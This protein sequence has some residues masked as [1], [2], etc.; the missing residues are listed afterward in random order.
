M[1]EKLPFENT[2]TSIFGSLVNP[3]V[4]RMAWRDSRSQRGRLFLFMAAIVA[5]IAALIAINS[6]G[7]NLETAVQT[8]AK[9]LL[10][11]D[12][13]L[14][15]RQEFSAESTALID[16]LAGLS[17]DGAFSKEIVFGSMAYFPRT[18]NTRLTQIRALSGAFPFYGALETA[19]EAAVEAFRHGEGALVDRGLMLQYQLNTGD[20]V[21]VGQTAFVILGELKQAPGQAD[22]GATIAPRVYIP[23]AN[24]ESTGL[25]TF[26]SRARYFAYFQFPKNFDADALEESLKP[27]LRALEL[28]ATT[29]AEQQRSFGR[30]LQNL[31]RFL[32][33]VGFIALLLGCLGVASSVHVYIRQK[34]ES[35][36]ILR[37]LGVPVRQTFAIFLIQTIVLQG[38]AA[39][40]GAI[41]GVAVQTGLPSILADFLP[42]DVDFS[43]SFA[44]IGEGLFIGLAMVFLFSLLPLLSV[45][46][47]S[48][49]L[50]IRASFET[51]KSSRDPLRWL[52]IAGIA[53]LI[54]LVTLYQAQ[55]MGVAMGFFG[56]LLLAFG[57]LAG[58]AKLLMWAVRRFFPQRLSFIWRQSLANLYRPNNQTLTLTLSLGLGIFLIS[59]LFLTQNTL[60]NQVALTDSGNQPNLVLFDIQIDQREAIENDIREAGL[61]ILQ[62][63][64]IVTMRLKSIAGQTVDDILADSTS[65]IPRWALSRE[66]RSTYRDSLVST[67]EI[68]AG[69]WI[70]RVENVNDTVPV[71]LEEG[72]AAD[73][74]VNIDDELV[75]DVQGVPIPARVASIRK[76]NWQRVQPNFFVLFPAGI[77]E[78]APQFFVLVTRAASQQVSA[79]VQQSIVRDFPNVSAI[80]LELVLRTAESILSKISFVIRFMALFSI[81]TGFVVLI[82]AVMTSRFQR[83]RESVLLRTLGA[84]RRQISQILALEYFYLGS[85]AALTG[86]I[87]SVGSGWALATFVFDAAFVPPTWSLVGSVALVVLLTIALGMLNS[88]GIAT[89]PPLEV[90]RAEG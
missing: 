47:V 16:S 1:N 61:P 49:L 86:L 83:I 53:V 46:K 4:W 32:N 69:K 54:F 50:A 42:V 78:E 72:I 65:S 66:Y 29:V 5:G 3:W 80:D 21:R 87:L 23:L 11:A 14:S 10:G 57:A 70:P 63:V 33:L 6:F 24:L 17:V 20:T 39:T 74:G 88:R 77:L 55:N 60:L 81:L 84:K 35:I 48:P 2:Q 8:Q 18:G 76:V 85:L 58:V 51:E 28:R 26:G 82:A 59:T 9:S 44:A 38:F 40:L 41:L 25:I 68:I 89:R 67:E 90:L 64:P 45:R 56:G 15:S 37:C 13:M 27:Q 62:N 34:L 31:Y 52:V 19:P 36:S 12:L 75:I 30:A 79:Q 7:R 22:A 73:L 71:S 43:I